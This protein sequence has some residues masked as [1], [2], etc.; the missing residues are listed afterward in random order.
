MILEAWE[1][2]KNNQTLVE[3]FLSS[4]PQKEIEMVKE[5]NDLLIDDEEEEDK[6]AKEDQEERDEEQEDN[7]RDQEANQ[8]Y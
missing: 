5:Y 3:I 4:T 7:K 2:L 1:H 8:E 6:N